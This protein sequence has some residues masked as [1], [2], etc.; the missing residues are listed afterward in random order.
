MVAPPLSASPKQ[1]GTLDYVDVLVDLIVDYEKR[2]GYAIDTSHVTA[3]DLI[4]VHLED[5]GQSVNAL[6]KELSIPQSNLADMLN[7]RRGWSKSVIVRLRDHFGIS[8]DLFLK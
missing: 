4:R 3:A 6:A 1:A 8:A 7:G 5:R 2:A